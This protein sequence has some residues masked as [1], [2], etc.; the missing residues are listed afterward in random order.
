MRS[1]QKM[2]VGGEARQAS[3]SIQ[4]WVCSVLCALCF[5]GVEVTLARAQHADHDAIGANGQVPA[6]ILERPVA[7]RQG[8]GKVH[9]EVTTKSPEA[10]A[11]YD[12]GL[13]YL[14][15]FVW[16]EAV[17]SFHQSL[18]A[19]PS[20]MMSYLELSD[21]YIGLQDFPQARAA[22]EKA[23]SLVGNASER[24]KARLTI[25][26]RQFDYLQD[27]GNLQ[28]YFNY[29][30]AITDALVANPSDP[31]L[32]IL[33][34][35]ADEGSPLAHG[36]GGSVDT[37][38]FYQTA[39]ALSPDNFAAHHYLAHTFENHGPTKNALEQSEEYVRLAPA[40]PHAHHM[41]GHNLRRVGRT[42][43]AIQEFLKA[44]EL[45]NDYYRAEN[46]PAQYDW[47]HAHNLQ[48][49]ALSYQA[50]GQM[51]AAEAAYREAYAQPAYVDLAEYNRRA[52]PEF[53]LE[54]GRAKEALEVSQDLV[55][56][57]WAMGRFAGHALAGRALLAMDRMEEA[58]N[59]SAQAEQEMEQL[60]TTAIKTLEDAVMLRA[61]ILLRE[62]NW[63][64]G[65]ALMEQVEEQI[66][67]IPGPDAWSEAVF[68]LDS[69]ARLACEIGDWELANYAARKMVQHDPSYAGGHFAQGLVAEHLGDAPT[70]RLE[71]AAAEKLWSKADADVQRS[72]VQKP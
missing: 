20:V 62:K 42:E 21:A 63:D 51:K 39:L 69:A 6:E 24:E 26:S 27:S 64:K 40:I 68:E 13:A 43:E 33:R 1:L 35:F 45:E 37:I 46:I 41:R 29:R 47:H 70:A 44:E 71:F 66:V 48:L 53:L 38:A 8:I 55:K 65:N 54:R 25:R 15:S 4:C 36:Q 9:E 30:L 50:L 60:S 22:L 57:R 34:G 17:R 52:W 61:E 2:N 14:H 23:Q 19:D 16:I 72:Q 18:R 3:I 10:Q 31:W 12:Q 32:W 58:K 67:A 59:E 56:S 28:K 49:L 5:F 11:F 7:L